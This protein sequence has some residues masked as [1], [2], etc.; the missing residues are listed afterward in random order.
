MLLE[1]NKTDLFL[2]KSVPINILH[3]VIQCLNSVVIGT[4]M[5]G[6]WGLGDFVRVP[7]DMW[8]I[9]PQYIQAAIIDLMEISNCEISLIFE[10]SMEHF[11]DLPKESIQVRLDSWAAWSIGGE[12]AFR[13]GLSMRGCQRWMLDLIQLSLLR[14]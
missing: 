2:R 12:R 8:S 10:D 5:S 13:N 3:C 1:W 14:T 6:R 4:R 9:N 7:R 11:V